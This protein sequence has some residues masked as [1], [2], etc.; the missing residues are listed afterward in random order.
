MG[1][2]TSTHVF[3]EKETLRHLGEF[4]SNLWIFAVSITLLYNVCLCF[5]WTE[6][7]LDFKYLLYVVNV[8]GKYFFE[9][10]IF[11]YSLCVLCHDLS[12]ALSLPVCLLSVSSSKYDS[13]LFPISTDFA[14]AR[15]SELLMV[16]WAP[17]QP[18]ALF[19]L[20]LTVVSGVWRQAF[21]LMSRKWLLLDMC[22]EMWGCECAWNYSMFTLTISISLTTELLFT[23]PGAVWTEQFRCSSEIPR[24]KLPN[25]M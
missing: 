5:L 24:K 12:S 17:K 14:V 15:L 21:W 13:N 6:T 22:P 20:M 19:M 7:D 25:I 4:P 11:I 10:V 18:N 8:E 2:Q 23:W 9:Q 16:H 3:T 1:A